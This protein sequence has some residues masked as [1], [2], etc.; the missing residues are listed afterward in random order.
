MSERGPDQS[1][2]NVA[3]R[4]DIVCRVHSVHCPAFGEQ[5]TRHVLYCFDH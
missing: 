2:A 5:N 1:A 3:T 4:H